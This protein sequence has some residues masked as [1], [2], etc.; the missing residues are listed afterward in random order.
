MQSVSNP[1]P[2]FLCIPIDK[3]SKYEFYSTLCNKVFEL[4]QMQK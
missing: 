4:G 3:Y 1:P 2:P